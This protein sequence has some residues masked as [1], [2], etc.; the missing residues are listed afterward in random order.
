M[1]DILPST[2]DLGSP[3]DREPRVLGVDADDA[4]DVLSALSSDT[5][6]SVL[7]ALHREPGPASDVADRVDTSLQNAQYHLKRLREAGLVEVGGTA[8]SEKGREMDVYAP[9]DR[10]LVL[11][12]GREEDTRGLKGTLKRLLGGVG[13]VALVSVFIETW[14]D[15]PFAPTLPF[16]TM[17]SGGADGGAATGQGGGEVS[18]MAADAAEQAVAEPTLWEQVVASPGALFFLGGVVALSLAVGYVYWRRSR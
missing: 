2:P 12:A 10:A 16:G 1:A 13:V 6:R 9:A 18:V 3:E 4:E 11:V 7:A 15:G 5:A 8:Y 14:L 17:A